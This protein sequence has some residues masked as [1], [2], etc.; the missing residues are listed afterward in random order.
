M[1]VRMR[2]VESI[3][4]RVLPDLMILSHQIIFLRVQEL[5]ATVTILDNDPDVP[6]LSI[7]SV[8]AGVDGTGVTEGFAFKFKVR[9]NQMITSSALPFIV[10]ADDDSAGLGVSIDGTKE[11]AIDTQ[12]TEFTVTMNALGDVSPS[13]NVNIVVTLAEHADYDTNPDQETIIVKVK[14]NDSP[15]ATNP[16]VTISGPHYVAE[17]SSFNYILK[18]SDAPSSE[19]FV[20][21]DVKGTRGNFLALN[22]GGVKTERI[23]AGSIEGMLE[24]ATISESASNSDGRITAEVLDGKGYAIAAEDESRIAETVIRDD[25]P[26]ISLSAPDSVNERDGTFSITCLLQILHQK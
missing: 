16:V 7:S 12:E 20:N 23:A 26:V 21:V 15:S 3:T 8:A 19:M 4:A 14:D 1:I 11:I 9:S 13:S 22:Q 6:I 18:A 17:G 25:L 2:I 10:S 5:T 24:V